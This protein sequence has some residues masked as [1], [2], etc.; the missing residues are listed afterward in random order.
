LL[1]KAPTQQEQIHYAFCLRALRGEWTLEQRRRYL[2]WFQRAASMRGGNSFAGF[3]RNCR[4]EAI[5]GMSEPERAALAEEIARE[6][7]TTS[8]LAELEARPFVREWTMDDLLPELEAAA[9]DLSSRDL[10]RGKQMFATAQCYRCHRVRGDGDRVG[11]DLTSVGGRF[12]PHDLLSAVIEPNK[13]ISDQYRQTNFIVNGRVITGRI[14]NLG[15]D[16]MQ[17][18]TDM[19]N[20]S[21]LTGIRS[22]EIESQEDSA[23]SAMPSGLLNTLNKEEILDLMAYLMLGGVEPPASP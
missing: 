11:P 12:S 14:I 13:V 2:D 15:G 18:L 4:Q 10:E 20:P 16:G 19:F 17:V 5:D 22:S 21:S 7:Q 6:P 23:V 8:P 3:L 9:G 1:E